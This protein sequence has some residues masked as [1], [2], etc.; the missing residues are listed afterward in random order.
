M[1]RIADVEHTHAR[2]DERTR[3]DGRLEALRNLTVVRGVALEAGRVLRPVAVVG[4]LGWIL[5]V[6]RHVHFELDVRDDPRLR[7]VRDVDDARGTH[8]LLD[9]FGVSVLVARELVELDQDT[10]GR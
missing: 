6:L 1:E 7:L 10:S 5:S 9:A 2:Q 3:Q 4:E 8:R